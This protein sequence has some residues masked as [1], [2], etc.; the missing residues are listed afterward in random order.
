MRC[1]ILDVFMSFLGLMLWNANI[2]VMNSLFVVLICLIFLYKLGSS[3]DTVNSIE[4][5][6]S[7]RRTNEEL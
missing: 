1:R 5:S 2:S 4:A 6:K 7:R 3:R